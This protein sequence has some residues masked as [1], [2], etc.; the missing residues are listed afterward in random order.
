MLDLLQEKKIF[1]LIRTFGFT[2][3]KAIDF[4]LDFPN[5]SMDFIRKNYRK[6]AN[7]RDAKKIKN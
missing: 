6:F 5:A 2:P 7:G 3:D 4:V 1:V